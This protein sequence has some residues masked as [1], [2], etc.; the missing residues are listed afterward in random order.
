MNRII[1]EQSEI[2]IDGTATFGGSRAEHVLA[3]LHGNVGQTLKTGVVNG[4]IGTSIIERIENLPPDPATGLPQG[5]ITVRCTHNEK[6]LPPWIDLILAP[7]RPRAFK[8]LLPQLASF[9]VR[10]IV[11]VGAAKVEKAFWGAQVLKPEIH[12]PLLIDGLMQAGVTAMPTISIEKSFRRYATLGR[13]AADFPTSARI[14]AHPYADHSR[15]LSA[16]RSAGAEDIPVLAVGPEGGWTDDELGILESLS[17]QRFSLGPR[18]LRTDTAVIAL[19]A[20]LMA[21]KERHDSRGGAGV[22]VGD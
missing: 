1:F 17:F 14:A 16:I 4:L 20:Q 7:P 5:I 13:L 6:P 21:E 18:I 12:R 10:R 22:G 2:A 19:L 11:L 8:R 9:G 15:P 3:V